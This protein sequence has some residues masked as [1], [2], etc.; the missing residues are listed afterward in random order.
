MDATAVDRDIVASTVLP[1]AANAYGDAEHATASAT[2]ED[3]A[4]RIISLVELARSGDKAAFGELYDHYHAAVFRFL[5]YRVSSATLAEDLTAETFFRALRGMSAFRW[6]GRD[7]GA[8]LMTI[9]RNLAADHF[10]AGRTRL[11]QTT[12]DTETLDSAADGP[13]RE[14]LAL[15]TS[16]ALRD[17]LAKLPL[18]QRECVVMRFLEGLSIAETADIM[19]RSVGAIKQLQLRGVRNLAKMIP[20]GS[21]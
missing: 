11:E 10:K 6:Q 2:D 20:V 21:L 14:V 19:G 4:A 7:F 15:L 18:E 5:Y 9:A 17:A 13:E 12:E 3:V 1:D 8:W 16:E